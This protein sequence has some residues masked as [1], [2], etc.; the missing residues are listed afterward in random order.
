MSGACG[1]RDGSYLFSRCCNNV[2]NT[3][4]PPACPAAG[5]QWFANAN[6]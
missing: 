2:L 6:R 3:K 4:I 1:K 5:V